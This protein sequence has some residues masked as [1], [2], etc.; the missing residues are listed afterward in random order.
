MRG[1]INNRVVVNHAHEIKEFKKGFTFGDPITYIQRA[2]KD[3][4]NAG[5]NSTLE[6]QTDIA[7]A[8]LNEM[9]YE[10]AKNSK[11]IKLSDEFSRAA[12]DIGL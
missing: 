10:Q 1:D 5:K 8:Q 7:V 9:M 12:W 2:R 4:R 6:E 3:I 11:D